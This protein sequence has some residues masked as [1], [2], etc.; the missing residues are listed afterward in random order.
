MIENIKLLISYD[1]TGYLGWQR[2]GGKQQ[3]QSIQGLLEH[4]IEKVVQY[5]VRIHGSG[6]TDAGVH[7][8]GRWRIF[9]CHLLF[10]IRGN[11]GRK[12]TLLAG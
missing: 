6:R 12:I 4:V 11:R 10:Y 5:P 2:L 7:A 1:G 9:L 3:G 8:K